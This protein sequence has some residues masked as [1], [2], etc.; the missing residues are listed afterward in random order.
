MTVQSARTPLDVS[1]IVP[2][3]GRVELLRG[4][5]SSALAQEGVEHEVI[6]VVDAAIR[7]TEAA[8]AALGDPRVR[9]LRTAGGVGP[10][11]GRNLGVGDAKGTWVSFLDDDDLWSPAKLRAQ[12]DAAAAAGADW[13]YTEAVDIDETGR[14]VGEERPPAPDDLH[15]ELR[16]ANLIPAGASNLLIR[17]DV[18]RDIGGFDPT[19]TSVT[20]WDLALRLNARGKP[21]MA[22]GLHVAYRRHATN[23]HATDPEGFLAEIDRLEAKHAD[24]GLAPDRVEIVRWL[25]GAQRRAG[26]RGR[27]ARLYLD[28]AMRERNPGNAVRAAAALG[29]E[30]VMAAGR[31][32]ARGK[33]SLPKEVEW[34]RPY[35]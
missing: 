14:I 26:K 24:I 27:A 29:G 31:R 33:P 7:E 15:R 6:V 16:Q 34:L 35:V 9:S 3:G 19:L 2:T 10:A 1:V 32:I 17:T 12:L 11:N 30:R 4:A 21:A 8:L 25:A 18:M 23:M 5:L 22:R 28:G 13:C 20:D